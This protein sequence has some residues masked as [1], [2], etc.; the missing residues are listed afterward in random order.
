MEILF[1]YFDGDMR[2]R[3]GGIM[4]GDVPREHYTLYKTN[5]ELTQP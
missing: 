4:G 2:V 1:A 3:G 5:I